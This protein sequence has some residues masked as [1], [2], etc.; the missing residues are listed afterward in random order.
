MAANLGKL[1]FLPKIL[2][3]MNYVPV[4]PVISSWPYIKNSGDILKRVK[5]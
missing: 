1:Y 5:H 2:K 4:R 3:R